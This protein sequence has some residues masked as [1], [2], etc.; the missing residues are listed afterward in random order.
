[1][2]LVVLGCQLTHAALLLK[3]ALKVSLLCLPLRFILHHIL[4]FTRLTDHLLR[5]L[6]SFTARDLTQ[7][8]FHQFKRM[9]ELLRRGRRHIQLVFECQQFTGARFLLRFQLSC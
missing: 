5:L 3:L 6:R 9:V 7:H 4:S 1:M 8:A 2:L